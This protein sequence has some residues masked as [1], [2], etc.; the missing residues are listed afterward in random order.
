MLL[1]EVDVIGAESGEDDV[2]RAQ[3]V[4]RARRADSMS[5]RIV[6]SRIS[7][8]R[9]AVR[10]PLMACPR[11]R[12]RCRVLPSAVGGVEEVDP[13]VNRRVDDR[14]VASSSIRV[15]K[16][17][18]PRPITETFNFPIRRVFTFRSCRSRVC[19]SRN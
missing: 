9:Y 5:H 18:Q 1:I 10:R 3:H 4:L 11:I 19:V 12:A 2:T 8:R 13:D 16:L 14:R 15:P 7:L 17:L 6:P